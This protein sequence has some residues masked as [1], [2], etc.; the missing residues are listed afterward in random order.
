MTTH[1][2]WTNQ[3]SDYLDDELPADERLRLE[4]HLRGCLECR[5]VEEELRQVRTAA[6]ALAPQRPD[7]DL[8]AS[9]AQRLEPRARRRVSFSLPAAM[10]AGLFVALASGLATWAIVERPAVP[11]ST[12]TRPVSL[13][14]QPVPAAF[15]TEAYDRAVDDLLQSLEARRSA[16]SP[17]TVAVVE[18]NL[19]V[20]DRA[21]TEARVAL[22]RDPGDAALASY[23]ADRQRVK[24][25][26][27]REVDRFTPAAP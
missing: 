11:E 22:E 19:E 15:T 3:L 6:R 17:R 14:S 20:I 12:S 10:A 23:L 8:W 5:L 13:A 2:I 21:I 7:A 25:A 9:I 27:L 26:V 18:R 1:E 16:L 24:L 4:E